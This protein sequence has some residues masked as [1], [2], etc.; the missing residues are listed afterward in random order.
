M[1]EHEATFDPQQARMWLDVLYPGDTPGLIHVSATGNWAGRAFTDRDRAVEY[2]QDMD[3]REGVYLRATTLRAQ[4]ANGERGSAADSLALPGL[5]ADIDL[6]GPGHKTDQALPPDVAAGQDIIRQ[7]GL[8]EPSLWVHSG[9]GLYPWWL[10]ERPIEVTSDNLAQLEKLSG[11]WQHVIGRSAQALGW[12]YGTGVGDLARVLRAPGTVN[13][14]A[15][16]ARPCHILHVGEDAYTVQQL[17][18]GLAAALERHP[19]PIRAPSPAPT[20]PNLG[21]RP[22]VTRGPEGISPNDDFE[23]RVSWDDELL[24]ADWT[25]TKGTPGQ[26]CEWRRPGKDTEGISATTGFDPGR[27]RLKV[28]TDATVL[29]QGEVYTKPGAYAFLHHGGDHRAATRE[30]ARLGFGTPLPSPAEQQR[31]ADEWLASLPKSDEDDEEE[32]RRRQ[33]AIEMAAWRSHDDIG[34]GQRVVDLY[35]DEVRHIGDEDRWAVWDGSRWAVD[36]NNAAI[37]VAKKVA[38]SM[39]AE[40]VD[41]LLTDL[42][43]QPAYPEDY[44]AFHHKGKS[45]GRPIPATDWLA[46]DDGAAA[47]AWLYATAERVSWLQQWLSWWSE[48]NSAMALKAFARDCRNMPRLKS[49]MA[50]AQSMPQVR[51]LRTTFDRPG[52]GIFV[53]ANATIDTR[54]GEAR[55]HRQDD[56]NTR[57]CPV[58]YQ[59][60]APAPLWTKFLERN[61]PDEQTRR[62]MQKLAGYAMT[63]DA[64]QKLL[65]LLHSDVGDTGKSLFLN[66]LKETMGPDYATGLAQS[67]LAPRR[68]GGDGGRDPDRHAMMGKRL[69]IGSEFRKSEPMDEAFMKRFTGRDPV[70]T[71]G[72]YSKLNVEWMPEGLIIIGT[73]KLFRIDLDDPAV[74]SRIVVVPFTV[75]FPKGHPERDDDLQR[76]IVDQEKAGIL[77]WLIQGLRL[78]RDEGLVPSGEIT[79]ATENYRSNSDHVSKWIETAVEDGR[80]HLT[81]DATSGSTPSQ[82]WDEFERWQRTERI[83]TDLK[84]SSFKARLE[85]L[86][87]PYS[88]IT[89]GPFKGKRVMKGIELTAPDN[90]SWHDSGR[91]Y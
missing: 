74:W 41:A 16:L 42:D 2:M 49:M 5:W 40:Q 20:A 48:Q 31:A 68:D 26:Y 21:H 6:A 39:R 53:T 66:V 71:R 67:T 78:Y 12:H 8:P 35:A 3:S 73:N 87:Y 84:L 56:W 57:L 10:F 91:G 90:T 60:D 33:K 51:A 29:T 83:L 17:H 47:I 11:Q 61:I 59:P 81:D 80:I 82:L 15:G 45:K 4:P 64:D 28:F 34:N 1:S 18:D 46:G 19:E 23:Q 14:K 79:M 54:T 38:E 52:A 25:V 86:G 88:K 9:G 44:P 89:S 58:D 85:E 69:L 62:Y 32:E 13:R 24:L 37:E 75:A 22:A 43:M 63:G 77:A 50:S 72:N 30:L 76:K 65:V 27:D 7:S 70:S 55:E 36:M